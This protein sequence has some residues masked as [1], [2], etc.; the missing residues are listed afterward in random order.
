MHYYLAMQH[1]EF[2]F[3]FN[4]QITLT[5]PETNPVKEYSYLFKLSPSSHLLYKDKQMLNI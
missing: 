2:C 1:E 3:Q 5:V 4:K